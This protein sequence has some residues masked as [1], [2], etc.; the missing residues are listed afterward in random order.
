MLGLPGP[1]RSVSRSTRTSESDTARMQP[2]LQ[3]PDAFVRA[4][5][6]E[7]AEA[8]L[9]LGWAR[10]QRPLEEPVDLLGVLGDVLQLFGTIREPD[11]TKRFHLVFE[12]DFGWAYEPLVEGAL[13]LQSCAVCLLHVGADVQ[14]LHRLPV[15]CWLLRRGRHAIQSGDYSVL[16]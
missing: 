11:A 6:P 16:R 2:A 3:S 1:T 4:S 8:V 13:H 15:G 5:L 14:K 12:N 9:F 7:V 10:P